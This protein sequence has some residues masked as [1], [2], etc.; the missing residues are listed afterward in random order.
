MENPLVSICIPV[1]NTERYIYGAI[2]SAL[3]QTYKNIEVIVLDDG[4]TD[5]THIICK[6]FGNK[7]RYIKNEK[8]MG[9][10]YGRWRLSKEAK[11]DYIVFVS[12]DDILSNHF[13]E[14][15]IKDVEDNTILYCGNLLI[16]GNGTV[17]KENKSMGFESH[18]DFCVSCYELA[19][20][21]TMFVNFSCLLV[22]KIAFEK[23]KFNKD[24]RLCED[25]DFLLN[26][27]MMFRYKH[28]PKCLVKYREHGEMTTTKKWDEIES[29]NNGI[30]E[31]FNRKL[32][33]TK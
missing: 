21:C 6:S 10:G 32:E 24:L 23:V 9:I 30:I 26:S 18:D 12:A 1:Y 14:E 25:L 31:R 2:K 19:H 4:S 27:M 8:N 33:E 20:K 28:V 7:I 5:E 15:M 22:P 17:T 13:V 29:I 16:D 3:I 11:G